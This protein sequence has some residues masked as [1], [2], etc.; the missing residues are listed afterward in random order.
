MENVKSLLIAA[1]AVIA[2]PKHWTQGAFAR[3]ANNLVA[4]S[5]SSSDACQWCA[6]GALRKV[7]PSHSD[8][9]ADALCLLSDQTPNRGLVAVFNDQVTHGQIM[10]IFDAAISQAD[11]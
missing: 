11:S 5:A 1:K 9:Y 6:V 2:D 4:D 3:R 10:E 8:A 7:D